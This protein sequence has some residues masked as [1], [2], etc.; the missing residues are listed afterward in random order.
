MKAPLIEINELEIGYTSSKSLIPPFSQQINEGAFIALIGSN[1]TGKS[2][3]LKTISGILEPL[4]GTVLLNKRSVKDYSN[5]DKALMVSIVL[6]DLPV[7]YYIRTEDVVALGRYPHIGFW[8]RLDKHDK[9]MVEESMLLCGI[10]HLKGRTMVSLS[11]GERQK[12]M[13]AK[14]LAQDTPII[15]L[16]EPAA[17]LDYPAKIELMQ[18]LKSLI[19]SKKK[20]VIFSSHDLD[21]VL[22]NADTIW[23]MS[24]GMPII[25]GSPEKLVVDGYI[26]NYFDRNSLTFDTEFGQFTDLTTSGLKVYVSGDIPHIRWVK[27]A[28]LRN[29]LQLTAKQISD[30]QIESNNNQYILYC[31]AESYF[32]RDIDTLI[33]QITELC[34][35][36][37]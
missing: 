35:R 20:T 12:T 37:N 11:D 4:S 7:D 6:T 2:T 15:I 5:E 21:L 10:S 28:L 30:I 22:R 29:G 17:F 16:D 23:A 31:A 36:I 8:G 34:S 26:N 19:A 27:N 18:L 32:C 25:S 1:G 3:L 13:I 33:K 9:E 14:A 24:P